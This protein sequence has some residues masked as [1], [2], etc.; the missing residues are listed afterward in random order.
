MGIDRETV[1]RHLRLGSPEPKPA[2]APLGSAEP[3]NSSKPAIAPLGS[4]VRAAES[5]PAI[6]PLGS[7]T[8]AAAFEFVPAPSCGLGRPS[9]CAPYRALILAGLE[10]GLSAQRIYQDLISEHGFDG[11]TAA[12]TGCSASWTNS[13]LTEVSS[14]CWGWRPVSALRAWEPRSKFNFQLQHASRISLVR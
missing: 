6:A 9:D 5:N 7:E 10:R 12:I 1:A 3:A 2:N 4:E 11:F 8:D 13:A 14:Q